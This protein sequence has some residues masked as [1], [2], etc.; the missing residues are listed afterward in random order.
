M[1]SVTRLV[2]YAALLLLLFLATAMAAQGW[3]HRQSQRLA[4]EATAGV[5]AQFA[6]ALTFSSRPPADWDEAYLRDLGELIGGTVSLPS[7]N[8]PAASPNPRMLTFDHLLT[9]GDPGWRG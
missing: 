9:T 3:L 6:K 2:G 8:T 4:N 1:K 7:E 5:R